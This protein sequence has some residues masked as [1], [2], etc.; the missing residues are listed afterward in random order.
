M[1]LVF[2]GVPVHS[3]ARPAANRA[4]ISREVIAMPADV[5]AAIEHKTRRMAPRALGIL[6]AATAVLFALV[7][8]GAARYIQDTLRDQVDKRATLISVLQSESV[9][10]P[11]WQLKQGE[12]KRI[13]E[14]LKQDPAFQ[15]AVV[16]NAEGKTVASVGKAAPKGT[17]TTTRTVAITRNDQTIGKY[18][19][20][21]SHA[22]INAAI[23][24]VVR[25]TVVIFVAI[26][27]AQLAATY[28]VLRHLLRPVE[29]MTA[30]MVQLAQGAD[31]IRVPARERTDEIGRMAESVEVFRQQAQ[32]KQR[33]HEQQAENERKGR[34]ERQHARDELADRFSQE[35]SGVIQQVGTSAEKLHD[36]AGSM[37]QAAQDTN[38]RVQAVTKAAEQAAGNVQTVSSAAQE[39]TNSIDEV[40]Q[41]IHQTSETARTARQRTDSAREQVQSLAQ[42]AEQIGGAVQQIQEIA[43]KTNLLA[44]NATIEAARAGEAGKG[45]AVVA[46]E[47][48][49][50]ANQTQN[51][52]AD[53]TQRIEKV[54]KETN[55]AVSV[56]ETMAHNMEEI[57]DA[58]SSIAS[59]VE[60]QT[61]ATREISRN[62]EEASTGVQTVSE[63]LSGLTETSEKARTAANDVLSAAAEL[64]GNAE[65]MRERVEGFVGEIRNSG[66]Q[67][68]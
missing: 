29:R 45:F 14:A 20:V 51:A 6:A 52:T 31:D 5:A 66:R 25:W 7:A 2:N 41:R 50:L 17:Q 11:L 26:L 13:L 30:V 21:Y 34:E 59:A 3:A 40:G 10:R 67:A 68:G 23:A 60:E 54:Q 15:R 16:T 53:I 48:K 55:E 18:Q 64:S 46:D 65:T 24:A 4:G 38:D 28:G 8:F 57:D 1:R 44:L 63:Q 62:V 35:V 56:I 9:A 12:V 47:V 39:L 42:A 43:E 58:A 49:S 36:T 19:V 27:G 61:S 33:L 37:S 32:E 22:N